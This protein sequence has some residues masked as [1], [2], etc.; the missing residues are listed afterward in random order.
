MKSG[1]RMGEKLVQSVYSYYDKENKIGTGTAEELAKMISK[2]ESYVR[3]LWSFPTKNRKL[4]FEGR[5]KPIYELYDADGKVHFTGSKQECCDYMQ[6]CEKSFYIGLRHTRKGV[7]NGKY[8]A[9]MIRRSGRKFYKEE[10]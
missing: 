9:L 3:R 2:S 7:R 4:V 10:F 5:I 6:V 8:G 1:G